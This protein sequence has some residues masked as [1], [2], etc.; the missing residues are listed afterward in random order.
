MS[1][2]DSV[3]DWLEKW[4]RRGIVNPLAEFSHLKA[5]APAPKANQQSQFDSKDQARG[6]VLPGYKYLGPFNG[7]DKGDPVNEADAAALKHDKAY[8]QLLKEGDNPY[9]NFNHADHELLKDLQKAPD[10]FGGNL[11][12]GVFQAKKRLLE[13]FG[14]VEPPNDSPEKTASKDRKRPHHPYGI[15]TPPDTPKKAK[16]GRGGADDGEQP[17]TSDGGQGVSANLGSLTMS[18]GGG[19]AMGGDNQGADGVGNSSGD[20]HCDTLWLGDSVITRSTRT[21]LLPTYN[22]H[23][24]KRINAGTGQDVNNQFVGYSTPWGIFDYNRFHCHFS[25]RDWQRLI[26]NN[27]GIRPKRM[28]FKLFNVQVKE[29][30]TTDSVTT[31]A[32]NLTST[33]QVFKD[34]AYQLPYVLGSAQVGTMPPFPADIYTVPQY[35]YCTLNVGNS[36]TERSAFY[37]LE[38]FPS[39]MLR[40][41]NNFEF[42]YEFES[43]PFHSMFAH[44]QSLD[45]LMNPLLGQYL[46]TFETVTENGTPRYKRPSPENKAIYYKNWLPAPKFRNQ[47]IS[48]INNQNFTSTVANNDRMTI[49]N[50][51][52]HVFLDGRDMLLQPGPAAASTNPGDASR[53]SMQN[54]IAYS[55]NPDTDYTVQD[56]NA[57]TGNILIT[58]EDEIRPT[59]GVGFRPWGKTVDNQQSNNTAPTTDELTLLGAMPG[60]VWQDRD[61][62]L[63]GPIWAKIPDTDG[64]FHP[65]PNIG[66]FGLKHPPPQILIKNTPVPANPSST[67]MEGNYPFLRFLSFINQ[68]STG[69]CTVTIEWELRKE[70]SKRWNPEIQFTNNWA[71]STGIQFTP[72]E[73]GLYKEPRLIGTRYLTKPL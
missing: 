22:N 70:H 46:M 66:G 36:G 6:L 51:G 32:N 69:Q 12:R 40:T 58:N 20:W 43:V 17:S 21:W 49:W 1:A 61:I 23:Q 2:A 34:D 47:M 50:S 45:R 3:P 31:I 9:V 7:L 28:H 10:T 63:Q 73:T 16:P 33:I 54:D 25:P 67:V 48:T 38:Y 72:D 68:Y 18:E 52:N 15:E 29:Y 37:C 39:N 59:N 56:Y 44:N 11:A 4:I 57:S 35:G 71:D 26:N 19:G 5:G 13:P 64:H 27:W 60:M 53:G 55:S 14:L 41:G 42:T 8:D 62:Y 30:T 24:Y 65:S